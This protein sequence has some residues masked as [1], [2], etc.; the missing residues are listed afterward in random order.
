MLRAKLA[1]KLP[2]LVR[3]EQAWLRKK[4]TATVKA[5]Q[6]L[7]VASSKTPVCLT[8]VPHPTVGIGHTLAEYNAGRVFAHLLNVPYAHCPLPEPWEQLLQFGAGDCSIP[9]LVQQPLKILRLPVFDKHVDDAL[10]TQLRLYIDWHA[11]NQRKPVLIILGYGQNVYDHSP[12]ELILRGQYKKGLVRDGVLPDADA[13]Q[14]K[15][16]LTVELVEK[17]SFWAPYERLSLSIRRNKLELSLRDLRVAGKVNVAVHIR[18]RNAVDLKNP[19]VHDTES[20]AYRMRYIDLDYFFQ[21]CLE[22]E[23]QYGTDRVHFNLF[24]QEKSEDLQVFDV[25]QSVRYCDDTDAYETFYN[26]TLSDVL[27]TSPSSFSF[28][29]GMLSDGV[30]IAPSPWWHKVPE[31]EEWQQSAIS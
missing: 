15:R 9:E 3:W 24:I 10:L 30:K 19:A 20:L 17:T 1:E 22:V 11:Q 23:Q 12:T 25:F 8:G 5:A 16:Q 14:A 28:K 7:S 26:M 27:I 4:F 18:R 21:R 13:G 29:A 6:S 31:N 2:A